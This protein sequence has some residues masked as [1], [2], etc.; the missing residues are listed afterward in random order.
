MAIRA[1]DSKSFSKIAASSYRAA[2][3][4]L[5]TLLLDSTWLGKALLYYKTKSEIVRASRGRLQAPILA[6]LSIIGGI[7]VELVFL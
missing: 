2:P 5:F 1:I 7:S 4:S 3:R 6:L